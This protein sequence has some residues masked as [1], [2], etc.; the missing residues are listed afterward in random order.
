MKIAISAAETSGDLIA[1]SLVKS[2][3]SYKPDYE[4][5]GLAGD[6]MTEVGCKRLWHADQVNVMG[7]SEVVKKLPS[8]LRLRKSI[9][10]HY[11]SDRPDIFIGVDSPDFN[12]KIERELKATWC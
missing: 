9:I 6:K 11:S 7:I 10:R 8:V 3:K 4:I 1:S 5:E 12:F 2:L